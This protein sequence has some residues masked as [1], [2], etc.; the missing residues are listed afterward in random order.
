MQRDGPRLRRG[1]PPARDDLLPLHVTPDAE[2]AGLREAGV[3]CGFPL[4]KADRGMPE[5]GLVKPLAI[6]AAADAAPSRGLRVDV[7]EAIIA[8]TDP[9]TVDQPVAVVGKEWRASETA[10][11]VIP[12]FIRTW[13]NPPANL[14]RSFSPNPMELVM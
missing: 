9:T 8:A 5:K 14:H 6:L 2:I 12:D 7:G 3:E 10:A 11:D 1:A 13:L 4:L